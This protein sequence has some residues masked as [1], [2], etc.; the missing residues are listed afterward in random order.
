MHKFTMNNGEKKCLLVAF[1][2]S[3]IDG[4][5]NDTGKDTG[6]PGQKNPPQLN[7]YKLEYTM[8]MD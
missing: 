7:G 5:E 2:L 1:L 4:N 6:G 3:V 8:Y